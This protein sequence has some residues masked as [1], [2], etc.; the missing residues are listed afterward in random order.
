MIVTVIMRGELVMGIALNLTGAEAL[1]KLARNVRVS[2]QTLADSYRQL[3]AAMDAERNSTG[4]ME[5]YFNNERLQVEQ[6]I[7][8]LDEVEDKIAKL[9]LDTAERIRDYVKTA[10]S[11]EAEAQQTSGKQ[12][13]VEQD[14]AGTNIYA[15][16]AIESIRNTLQ[17]GAGDP[18]I[19][20]LGGS[21]GDIRKYLR[22]HQ[23]TGYEVHHI[24]AKA[25]VRDWGL[26][27]A[28]PAIALLLEDHE[29]TDSF[30]GKARKEYESF[31]PDEGKSTSYMKLARERLS[32]EE[33][34]ALVSIELLNIREQCGHRYDGA[35]AQYLVEIENYISIHGL[36]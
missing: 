10:P 2:S 14:H 22:E 15:K 29:K 33:F 5:E 24:P 3:A 4:I 6:T 8:I 19:H 27:N 7:M 28:L 11:I 25:V 13:A 31:L 26:T 36:P 17:L 32:N 34:F 21:Y 9:L 30:R 20:Q 35:I 18:D 23:I 12:P 16:R 1:E